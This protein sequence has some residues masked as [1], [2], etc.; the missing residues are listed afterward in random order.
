MAICSGVGSP[1]SAHLRAFIRPL[2]S[3]RAHS[4]RSSSFKFAPSASKRTSNGA[5]SSAR[6]SAGGFKPKPP[7]DPQGEIALH[8]HQEDLIRRRYFE[9]LFSGGDYTLAPK[10]LDP[11]IS[12]KDMVRDEHY[13]GANEV[14]EY[15]R[16]V[17][18]FYPGFVVRATDIAPASDGRSMF[19]AFE[20]H[21]AEGMPLF[22]GIDRF[23]FSNDGEKIVEVNVY[24]SNWQG[25][26]G[27]A[28]RKAEMEERMRKEQEWEQKRQQWER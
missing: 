7:A 25:A 22:K 21:A 11:N 8:S 19:V 28:A 14:V 6:S 27:H 24:R 3:L 15:M 1:S 20:G 10:I 2:H 13:E 5:G 23:Y 4:R 26:K 17:K 18:Q 12:H 16:S 9:E